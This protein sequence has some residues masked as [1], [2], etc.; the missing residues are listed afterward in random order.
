[1]SALN[2]SCEPGNREDGYTEKD[3]PQT[4]KIKILIVLF[5]VDWIESERN[6]REYETAKSDLAKR[7]N[8]FS[9]RQ[10]SHT[11]LQEDAAQEDGREYEERF[12]RSI[13]SGTTETIH[14]IFSTAPHMEKCGEEKNRLGATGRTGKIHKTPRCLKRHER[15]GTARRGSLRGE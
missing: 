9:S 6:E 11:Y 13:A 15:D 12:Q 2:E 7:A 10:Y 5:P 1:M 3:K 14:C 8:I 4:T